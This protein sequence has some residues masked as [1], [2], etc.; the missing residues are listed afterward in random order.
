[1]T[2]RIA[3]LGSGANGSAI[4]A[5]LTLAGLDVVLVDQWPEHVEAMRSRGL[6]IRLPEETRHVPVR[7]HHLCEVATLRE[8]FDVVLIVMKAYDARWAAQLIE[9][10]VAS[11]GLV[12]AVQNGMSADV[13]ADVVGPARSLASVIEITSQLFEPGVVERH[14]PWSRSWFAV[15]SLGPQ[16]HGRE[17][18]VADLLRHSG[19]VDVVD[20][21][22][23]AKWMKLV[24][25]CTTLVPTAILGLP[26]TAA[27]E[28]PGMRALMVRAG[29]EALDVGRALGHPVLPIFGLGPDDLVERDRV[30]DTLLDTLFAGFVLAHS[31]T[32]ILQDWR[33]GRHSEA[34]DINGEVVRR[35]A[36]LGLAAPV[37]AA[38]VEIAHRIERGDLAPDRGNVDLLRD[39]VAGGF[40][41]TSR[42]R[43]GAA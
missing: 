3:V 10:Y 25:N 37:N 1:M 21:I 9:P 27:A 6:T 23:A 14:S 28:V 8:R 30:V 34:D 13:V 41:P 2:Q 43:T 26:M 36:Q 35:A 32:T 38:V 16:T 24:S 5:D 42:F 17:H 33:K 7:T 39:L 18:V 22:R 29:Q 11:D 40:V 20:D 15:G 12:V 19:P 4:G 31:T